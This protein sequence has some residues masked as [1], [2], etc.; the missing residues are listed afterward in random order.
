MNCGHNPAL[1]FQANTGRVTRLNSSC[2]PL[3]L[4]PQETC[5]LALA[6]LTPGDVIIFYTDGVTEARNRFGEEF[7]L[8][9][10]SE[11]VRRASSLSAENLM[12]NIY[13]AAANFC[14]DD[15]S[16]DVTILVVKCDFE[17]SC[18]QKPRT[19]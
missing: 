10:L 15:F 1:L 2:L 12:A 16:D 6:E 14:S 4:S 13:D 17:T 7:G 3:G 19:P 11:Q 9:R 5:E 18:G 8:A